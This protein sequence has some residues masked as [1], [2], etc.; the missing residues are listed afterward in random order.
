MASGVDQKA[1]EN[2]GVWEDAMCVLGCLGNTAR[3]QIAPFCSMTFPHYTERETQFPASPRSEE[4][5]GVLISAWVFTGTLVSSHI[6]N[7]SVTV[8]DLCAVSLCECVR[9]PAMGRRPA[10]GPCLEP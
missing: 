3:P 6:R 4:F 7:V 2:T 10:R 9:W 1:E 5:V 8:S